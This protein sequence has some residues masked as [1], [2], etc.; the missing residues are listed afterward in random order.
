MKM[1]TVASLVFHDKDLLYISNLAIR[2]ISVHKLT[3]KSTKATKAERKKTQR[4]YPVA[5]RNWSVDF[6]EEES[7][8]AGSMHEFWLHRYRWR[9]SYSTIV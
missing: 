7:D 5:N 3:N 9:H 1:G 2:K 6:P 4:E 8:V